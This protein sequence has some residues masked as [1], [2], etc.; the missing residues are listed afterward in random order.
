MRI[1]NRSIDGMTLPDFCYRFDLYKDNRLAGGQIEKVKDEPAHV[2]F[3]FMMTQDG[4]L[5][6]LGG[7]MAHT[8]NRPDIV[9][10]LVQGYRPDGWFDDLKE[11]L[12]GIVETAREAI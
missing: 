1:L 11:W 5:K 7:L 9:N 6:V 3:V 8:P 10:V 2:E 12:N 4:A